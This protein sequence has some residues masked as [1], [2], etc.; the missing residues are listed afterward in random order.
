MKF[1]CMVFSVLVDF[2]TCNLKLSFEITLYTKHNKLYKMFHLFDQFIL[3][4]KC[5]KI[6]IQFYWFGS[7]EWVIAGLRLA[8]PLCSICVYLPHS[9]FCTMSIFSISSLFFN[10]M[11]CLIFFLWLTLLM[12]SHSFCD[13]FFIIQS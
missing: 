8:F 3:L 5:V 12:L 6:N 7:P 9:W 1:S 13:F 4:A 11:L 10:P 2:C